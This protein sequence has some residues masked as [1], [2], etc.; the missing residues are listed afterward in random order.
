MCPHF[1]YIQRIHSQGSYLGAPLIMLGWASLTE[2]VLRFRMQQVVARM[3]L[4][5]SGLSFHALRRMGVTLAFANQVP[6]EAIRAHG[7]WASD[8]VW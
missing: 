6:M 8:A 2:K 4:S 1:H 5:Q 3:N 7:S